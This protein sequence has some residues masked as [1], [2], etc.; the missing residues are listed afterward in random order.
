[1][2]QAIM[3]GRKTMTRRVVKYKKKIEKPMIGFSCFTQK[4]MFSVRGKHENG[5]FG[6]SFF[7]LP[8]IVGDILWVRETFRKY[9]PLDENDNFQQPIIE[10]VADNPQPVFLTDGDGGIELNKDGT[11]K[12][13]PWKPSIFMP[14][15]AC[16]IFLEITGIR[17]ERLQNIID[18]DIK[19]EGIDCPSSKTRSGG[20]CPEGCTELR[21]AWRNLW[22]SING[23]E[24][25]ESN[26]WV[27]VI[28]FKKTERP[29]G[30]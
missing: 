6:E 22:Q 21:G 11:E 20:Y 28:S 10:Y 5:D 13:I 27:W 23:E 24:S 25:W 9:C 17:V 18:K 19:S 7:K 29:E 12:F 26:P 16:R 2:V 15:A 1:M 30:F 4:D 8:Y 14:K 3:E